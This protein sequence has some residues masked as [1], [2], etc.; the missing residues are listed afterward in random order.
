MNSKAEKAVGSTSSP[1]VFADA[2]QA[3]KDAT[4][5]CTSCDDASISTEA[6]AACNLLKN[7]STSANEACQTSELPINITRAEECTTTFESYTSVIK[8]CQDSLPLDTCTVDCGDVINP[9]SGATADVVA[10]WDDIIDNE[11]AVKGAKKDCANSG[12][13]DGSFF[14]CMKAVKGAAIQVADCGGLSTTMTTAA[15]SGRI[16]KLKQLFKV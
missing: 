10:C 3:L 16:L 7:C 9:I 8:T 11:A 5:D 13:P 12:G 14:N 6:I 15:P 1:S 4:N 2:S